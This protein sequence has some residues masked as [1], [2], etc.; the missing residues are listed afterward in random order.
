MSWTAGTSNAA[1]AISTTVAAGLTSIA[2]TNVI[3]AFVTWG[4]TGGI[5]ITSVSD[6]TNNLT[7][8]TANTSD[9]QVGSQFFYTIGSTPTGNVTYTATASS[10]TGM[11]ICVMA[12]NPSGTASLDQTR[13]DQSAAASASSV[14]GNI[15]TTGTDELVIGGV[16]TQNSRTFSAQQINAINAA[17]NV[18]AAGG[19][20]AGNEYYLTFGTTFTGQGTATISSADRW[21]SSIISFNNAGG[22]ASVPLLGQACL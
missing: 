2:S 15:T 13:Q 21:S 6:G 3:V 19:G 22:G 20:G 8:V 18:G 4:N 14:T 9:T 11:V 16:G 1:A 7:A 12:F 17:A 10:S 5:T